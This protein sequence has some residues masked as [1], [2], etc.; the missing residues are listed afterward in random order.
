[1]NTGNG[2]NKQNSG[3]LTRYLSALEVWALSIGCAVGW[4]AFVMPGTTFLPIAGPLGTAV[5]MGI[6]MLIMLLI[7]VNY[8]FLMNKYPD[9]GGTLTYSIRAFGFDHGLLSAWFLM[10]V[11]IAIMWANA[12]ATVL[13]VRNLFGDALQWGFH[14]QVAGYHVYMGEVLLTLAVIL[15][16][17]MICMRSK[18]AAVV[19]Q[20]IM[21]ITLVCGVLICSILVLRKSGLAALAPAIAPGD[22]SLG[23]QAARIVVL[24]PWA[25]V[26]FE[27]ISNSTQG[28]KFSPKKSIWVMLAALLA[29]AACYILLALVAA[30]VHPD[31][32]GSWAEYVAA[33]GEQDALA[34][35]PVFYA[36]HAVLGK[37]GLSILGLS[38]AA[39]IVTGLIGNYIAASRLIYAMTEDGILPERFGRLDRNGNPAF[40]LKFL[41]LISL[42]IPFAGRA[43]IGWIVDVNTIGA[44]IAY[45]YTSASAYKLAR[46]DGN[47]GVA[48]TGMTGTVVSLLFFLYFMVP[49]IRTV[50]TLSTESYLILIV[51]SILGVLFFRV[52]FERD[53]Q[54]RFGRSTAVW[55]TMLF[56]IFFASTLWLRESTSADA[57]EALVDLSSYSETQLARHGV[58]PDER[59]AADAE[60][61]LEQKVDEVDGGITSISRMHLTVIL[62]A[63]L[64]MFN[65]YQAI[66]QQEK[67]MEVQKLKAEES[68]RAKSTFLSNMSH[69]L[70]TP[71]NAIIGYTTLAKRTDGLSAETTAYLEK[72]EASSEHLLSLINDILDM[73]RIEN[74][75]MELE[76]TR[77]DLIHTMDGVRDIFS[78]QMEAKRLAF[79]VDTDGVRDRTV[80][81]DANRFNR[82]LLNLISNAYKFTPEGGEVAVTLA[83][84]GA[85]EGV[86]S[87]E[88]RVRDTGMGMSP[89]FAATVFDAYAREKTATQIQGTGLGMAITKSIVDLMGGT[90][91]VETEQG[92]GTEFIVR[93]DFALAD[94]ADADA[95]PSEPDAAQ[96]VAG[97]SGVRLLLVDDNEINR[98]IAIMLLEDAGFTID[99]AENGKLALDMVSAS[100]PGDYQAVLM[101]IQMPVMNG[102]EATRAIRALDDSALA[103]IPIIAMTA[104]A[105]AED[106]QAA[107]DAGMNGHIAKPIDVTKMLQELSRVLRK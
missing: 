106:K 55:V 12:T 26:G 81:C 102:Y 23:W 84:T 29:G 95:A 38:V 68:S 7:G 82:V 69:D 103:S 62:I 107:K 67:R 93:A 53:R 27:S 3:G 34:S 20:T 91:D 77:A 87:Y 2:S 33:L 57:K 94:E 1:M 37:A 8:H 18:R 10:L 25:Y 19:I 99:T 52:V 97:F 51:W 65:I 63:L 100:K 72:I 83:Q 43:A 58:E 75:K 85:A 22:H 11:Y 16:S 4:G 104:N 42:A 28:F 74:G 88:L 50:S 101:D 78:M 90:I 24:T 5:G 15:A 17:G 89:E 35:I 36:V 86:G 59:E 40:S 45:A 9:A 80:L 76:L 66:I 105:F 61:Y 73:S 46:E 41:M 47:T 32:Y 6:G 13:I 56:L 98:E 70:R 14:Y 21:A 64:L 49:S 54:G 79:S 92:K 31:G 39:G 96:P 44:L 71:M 30:A 60:Q 48:V